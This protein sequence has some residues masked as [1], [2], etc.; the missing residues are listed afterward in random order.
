MNSRCCRRLER[1]GNVF[2]DRY[3]GWLWIFLYY[4]VGLRDREILLQLSL[5]TLSSLVFYFSFHLGFVEF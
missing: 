1:D 3:R 4:T 2:W 5:V